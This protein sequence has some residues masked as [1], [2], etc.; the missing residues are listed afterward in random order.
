MMLLSLE[1]Q[2]FE[3]LLERLE[4]ICRVYYTTKLF[5]YLYSNI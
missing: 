2:N 1:E 5:I 3:L 4:L